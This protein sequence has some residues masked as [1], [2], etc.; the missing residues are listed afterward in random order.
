MKFVRNLFTPSEPHRPL[1]PN[2]NLRLQNKLDW[3]EHRASA[4]NAINYNQKYLRT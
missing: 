1:R 3:K 2:Q 4:F